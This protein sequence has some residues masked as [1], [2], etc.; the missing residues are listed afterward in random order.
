VI[1]GFGINVDW[2]WDNNEIPKGHTMPFM[3]ALAT[4]TK[5]TMFRAAFPRR[6]LSLT[7]RGREA[8]YSYNEL[9]VGH[10]NT[11]YQCP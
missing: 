8:L 5:E 3:Q 6:F 9:E 2:D 11:H 4:S 1:P 7:K 10:F